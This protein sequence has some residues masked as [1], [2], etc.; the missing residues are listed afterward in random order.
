M[1]GEGV[2]P[3]A[4]QSRQ[5]R[6][7]ERHYSATEL[8]AL[9]VLEAI[10][11]F[12]HFLYGASF[13]VLTDHKPLTSLLS[14]KNLNRRL[15]GMAL[16][17]MLYDVNNLYRK[18][19]D[20]SNTDGLSRQAWVAEQRKVPDDMV[21]EGKDV[22]ERMAGETDGKVVDPRKLDSPTAGAAVAAGGTVGPPTR[23]RAEDELLR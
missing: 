14:S 17:L 16:K 13:T 19:V 7:A 9:A 8:E 1:R 5:L 12:Q 23:M 4:F 10:K 18:G 11:Y 2:L 22:E 3:V 6:G 20:N 21:N 15:H